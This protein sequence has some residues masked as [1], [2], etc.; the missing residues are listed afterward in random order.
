MSFGVQFARVFDAEFFAVL[1]GLLLDAFA[2]LFAPFG[3]VADLLAGFLCDLFLA[4]QLEGTVPLVFVEVQQHFLLQ[5]VGPVVY[6]DRV[7]VLV[8]AL[9]H[10]LDRRLVQMPVH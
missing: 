9:V 1:L 5:L 7:V 6:V 2:P 10:R 3:D 4:L 8:Q